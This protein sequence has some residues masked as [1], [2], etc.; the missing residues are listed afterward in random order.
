MFIISAKRSVSWKA[1]VLDSCPQSMM[2]ALPVAIYIKLAAHSDSNVPWHLLIRH[3]TILWKLELAWKRPQSPKKGS[4]PTPLT[5]K[6]LNRVPLKESNSDA[7]D[8]SFWFSS[9]PTGD[10]FFDV[11]GVFAWRAQGGVS[12]MVTP[13]STRD[14]QRIFTTRTWPPMSTLPQT[15]PF[16]RPMFGL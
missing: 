10:F 13:F 11:L 6:S 2:R 8:D 3:N 4:G 12:E 7:S 5:P 1:L 9:V 16:G 15:C 14:L